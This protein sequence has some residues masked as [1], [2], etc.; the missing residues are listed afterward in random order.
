VLS[1]LD[2]PIFV[3][4]DAEISRLLTGTIGGIADGD[5]DPVIGAHDGRCQKMREAAEQRVTRAHRRTSFAN[6]R[7]AALAKSRVIRIRLTY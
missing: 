2:D 3:R 5:P 4:G 6:S 7:N 1:S